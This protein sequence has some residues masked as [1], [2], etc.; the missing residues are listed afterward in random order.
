MIEPE[1]FAI[2]KIHV[3]L[4]SVL[5]PVYNVERY[6]KEAIES[7]LHQTMSQFE[8]I[9]I[10]D[11]SSDN[12][13]EII[14]EY[15]KKDGRIK[16]SSRQNKGI[17]ATRNELLGLAKGR[18]FAIMDSDDISYPNRL[19]EQLNFLE[20]NK[21]YAIV[22]CQDLL[23]DPEGCPIMVINNIFDHD[24]IDAANLR[25]D[26]FQTLNAYM[27]VTELVRDAG[28][29]RS[30]VVYAEDRDLFLR[31]AEIGKVSV[32]PDVLYK[33]RQH[34]QSVCAEKSHEID[35]SVTAVINDAIDRRGLDIPPN[36]QN[37]PSDKR[38][39]EKEDF[40]LTWA[41]F[42]FQNQNYKTANKYAIKLLL[43]TPFSIPVW[44][45][46]YCLLREHL[47]SS[48]AQDSNA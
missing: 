18:Y 25:T 12:S 48:L 44:N 24:K 2:T 41:W 1:E 47:R 36:I 28:G 5:M 6:L 10:D 38:R 16:F 42:A 32:L 29:Y 4:V 17:V 27:A 8:F 15:T 7:V 23:V 37:N 14:A 21:G 45:L 46:I 3:P 43:A 40:Y 26:N 9:I 35:I 13:K 11:G 39:M 22:G 34:Y 33:Y 19:Q 30:E 20:N 31:L